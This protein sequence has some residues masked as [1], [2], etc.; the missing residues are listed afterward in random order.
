M[1]VAYAE[2]TREILNEALSGNEETN[3]FI[4]ENYFRFIRHIAGKFGNVGLEYDDLISVGHVGFLKALRTFDPGRGIKFATYLA[5]CVKNE[6]LMEA[7]RAKRQN[8]GGYFPVSIDAPVYSDGEGSELTLADIVPTHEDYDASPTLN[9]I[10]RIIKGLLEK[11]SPV[12]RKAV[13][14]MLAGKNQREAAAL[15]GISQTYVS[16]IYKKFLE[17][18]DAGLVLAGIRETSYLKELEQMKPKYPPEKVREVKNLLRETDL[19]YKEIAEKA[20]VPYSMVAYYGN[21]ID[22]D[23]I[24]KSAGDPARGNGGIVAQ[25]NESAASEPASRGQAPAEAEIDLA[26]VGAVMPE[27]AAATDPA[28]PEMPGANK[29][30]GSQELE[31]ERQMGTPV[32]NSRIERAQPPASGVVTYRLS[33][34]E[35]AARYGPPKNRSGE[36][37]DVKEA[38]EAEPSPVSS[39]TSGRENPGE[40]PR[41]GEFEVGGTA[42]C[43][44]CGEPEGNV[45]GLVDWC[46][47]NIPAGKEPVISVTKNQTYL[48]SV[49]GKIFSDAGVRQVRV[50]VLNGTIVVAPADK[51]TRNSFRVA[52]DAKSLAAKIG[53]AG[54]VKQLLAK[55]VVSG[56]YLLAKNERF[57]WW[58]TAELLKEGE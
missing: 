1:S 6:I 15:T 46:K 54:L 52:Y 25:G 30:M 11:M 57:G 58:E 23:R 10:E 44:D 22:R 12:T 13:A 48:N 45:M 43:G 16:R 34:E 38:P 2:P 49:A 40:P 47:P 41:N 36:K 50:G 55:G 39:E 24:S 8:S 3:S 29:I 14:A 9:E 4:Y 19:K 56:K 18:L 28:E 33:P 17:K 31:G 53:G 51:T 32:P 5:S 27:V 7:R 21:Q 26:A 42:A 35:L 37:P 20:G